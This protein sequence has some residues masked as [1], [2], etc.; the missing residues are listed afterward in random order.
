MPASSTPLAPALR[1]CRGKLV[2]AAHWGDW[3][4]Y[5]V[6]ISQRCFDEVL[7]FLGNDYADVALLT[8]VDTQR[9]W[10][11]WAVPSIERLRRYQESG[12]VGYIGM[13]SHVPD[14]ALQAVN[15]GL[16]DVL[17]FSVNMLERTEA[18]QALYRACVERGVGLVAMKVYH[19]GTLLAVGGRPTGITPAQC[20]GYVLSLPVATTVPGPKNLA[21]WQA[22]LACLDAGAAAQEFESVTGDLRRYFEGQCVYCQH[23]LPCPEGVEIG[24][25]IQLVDQAAAGVTAGLQAGYDEFA[26]KASA[27]TEC[28]ECLSR[29]PFDVDIFSQ[30]R[31]AVE[32]FE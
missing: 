4:R 28:G 16:L 21:E 13:S 23:C 8:M 25:T 22:T 31:R 10:R 5:E 20:L 7:P 18:N 11:E 24:W 19:G 17:M 1:S 3:A 26:V 2:V 12:R 15:S 30:L 9:H 14:L 27:C 32:L 29:C 6:D